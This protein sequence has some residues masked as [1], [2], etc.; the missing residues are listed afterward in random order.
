[1][2]KA[3]V[4]APPALAALGTAPGIHLLSA[5][6]PDDWVAAVCD[7]LGSPDS[8]RQLG[9]AGRLYVEKHHHW[10]RCLRPLLDQIFP[11]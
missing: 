4:A 6:T 5:S 7:L 3:V 2:G 8:R 9:T 10:D 11:V 1:M